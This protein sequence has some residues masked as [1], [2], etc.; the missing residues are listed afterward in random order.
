LDKFE[1]NAAK[2]SFKISSDAERDQHINLSEQET[3]D[4]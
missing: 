1:A 4:L 2:Q 3:R